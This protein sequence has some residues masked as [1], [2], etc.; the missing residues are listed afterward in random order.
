MER[1]THRRNSKR[2]VAVVIVLLIAIGIPFIRIGILSPR[3]HPL[4]PPPPEGALLWSADHE[5][6]DLSQW[7]QGQFGEAVFNTGTGNVAITGDVAHSGNYALSL[8]ISGAR[9]ET[10]AARLLRWHDNPVEG[11]YS[12]WFDFPRVY[13][14]A[15]WW[16]VFQFKSLGTESDPMW[17]L[18]VGNRPDGSM[19][20]YLWDALTNTSYAPLRREDISP[21]KWTEVTAY[22]RRATDRTGRITIWQDGVLLFDVDQVQTA[23][24]DN[25]HWGVGNYT[26]NIS[27]SDA[28]IYVDDAEIHGVTGKNTP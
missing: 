16:N 26:D 13:R 23:I 7:T 27:P 15:E 3:I 4:Q 6:G 19:Y 10:E 1:A 14:P 9:G 8:S 21:K 17:V 18:N 12:V 5:T 25:V 22:Y 20:F 11:Y 24:A 2:R 28:T